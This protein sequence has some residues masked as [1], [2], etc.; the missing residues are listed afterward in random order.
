MAVLPLKYWGGGGRL[1]RVCSLKRFLSI[2]LVLGVVFADVRDGF[3]VGG[4]FGVSNESLSSKSK[5]PLPEVKQMGH[6]YNP[7]TVMDL[8][9]GLKKDLQEALQMLQNLNHM[10]VGVSKAN[11]SFDKLSSMNLS[12]LNGM[13]PHKQKSQRRSKNSK[14]SLTL[15]A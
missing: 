2:P 5:P 4:G 15:Q 9:K 12:D 13:R 1:W 6:I 3:F 11:Q 8:S 10:V 7:A 14:P